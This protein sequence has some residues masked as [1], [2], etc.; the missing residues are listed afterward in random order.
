MERREGGRE[1]RHSNCKGRQNVRKEN[2]KGRNVSKGR[3]Q[4]TTRRSVQ[5]KKQH[6][7]VWRKRKC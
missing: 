2:V 7:S 1:L 4:Y 5:S 6:G 3:H